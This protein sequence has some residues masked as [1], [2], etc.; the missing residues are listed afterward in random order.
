MSEPV[1]QSNPVY[2][3]FGKGKMEGVRGEEAFIKWCEFFLFMC[4]AVSEI[5][6]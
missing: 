5:S 1:P 6:K 3:L 2:F 4:D